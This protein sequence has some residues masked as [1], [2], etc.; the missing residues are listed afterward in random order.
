MKVK[1]VLTVSGVILT[2]IF[3]ILSCTAT[4]KWNWGL[5]FAPAV[6]CYVSGILFPTFTGKEIDKNKKTKKNVHYSRPNSSYAS[7]QTTTTNTTART[8]RKTPIRDTKDL[9]AEIARTISTILTEDK[10]NADYTLEKDI[11][12]FA[13]SYA[14]E[15]SM[16]QKIENAGDAMSYCQEND[17]FMNSENPVVSVLN[18]MEYD[19][20][21]GQTI[22]DTVPV[23][24]IKEKTIL[25]P[26]TTQYYQAIAQQNASDIIYA[27][28]KA[29][30][31]LGEHIR[32]NQI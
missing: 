15:N 19:F 14:I 3:L 22:E 4:I 17:S 28:M 25:F 7:R 1:T 24:T 31:R 6:L 32:N 9:H 10:G 20:F 12:G 18:A 23:K 2:L 30:M 26:C 11:L 21:A 16:G 27:K 13:L 29:Y 8:S 5:I